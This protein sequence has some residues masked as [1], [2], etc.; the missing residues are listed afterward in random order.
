MSRPIPDGY[1]DQHDSTTW[2]VGFVFR[3]SNVCAMWLDWSGQL[4][5]KPGMTIGQAY[6]DQIGE[7]MPADCGVFFV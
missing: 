2:N 5:I 1:T 6:E 4:T 7:P 3:W